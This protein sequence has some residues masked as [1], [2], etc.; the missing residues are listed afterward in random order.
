MMPDQGPVSGLMAPVGAETAPAPT[1]AAPRP[2][3]LSRAVR[4]AERVGGRIG[5]RLAAAGRTGGERLRRAGLARVRHAA[6]A[7][8]RRLLPP[9][10][11]LRRLRPGSLFLAQAEA[12]LTARAR[13]WGAAAPLFARIAEPSARL[14]GPPA[15]ALLRL[16]PPGPAL[17]LAVPMRDRPSFLPEAEAGRLVVYTAAFGRPAALPPVLGISARVRFLCFTDQ[18]LAAPGWTVLATDSG[19]DPLAATAFHKIR[20]SEALAK[21]APEARASLWLDPDRALLGNPDTLFA[22]WLLPQDFAL[23]RHPD[24]HWRAMAERHLL[25]GT[26]PAPQLLAQSE[27]FAA[28]GVPEGRGGCDTGMVW[29]R[30]DA[31]GV[32]ALCDA[33]WRSWQAAPGADDLALYRALNSPG[34]APLRP[35]I[36]PERLGPATRNL[37]VAR[38]SAAP[39]RRRSAARPARP[40]PIVFLSAARFATFASTFLRGRQL[41]AMVAAAFPDYEVRFTEDA[42]GVRDAVVVLTKGA[43]ETLPPEA[44]AALARR[45]LAAIGCWD[46]VRPEPEKVRIL[47]A[48]M[49]LSWRQTLDLNR[50]FPETPAYL[51]THH[52]NRQVPAVT[53]PQDRLRTCYFGDLGNTVR[54]ASLAGMVDL[55]GINTRDVNDNW[56][57]ALP[58]YN[59]HWIVRRTRPWDSWKPFLKGF[60][61]ARC[62][63]PVIVAADDGDAAHYLGDD[64]PFYAASLAAPDLEMA[65]ATAAAGFGGPDWTRARDIMAQVAARSSDAQVCAEFRAMVEEV[66][67]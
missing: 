64:Y 36:L 5:H 52:V 56:L 16:P 57:S 66:T 41:S 44:I 12:L 31:E 60:V 35:A 61:A 47:D 33:W 50:L 3:L 34:P 46:D 49:T 65:M 40:L 22:R 45:N 9:V 23:W 7:R 58:H 20:A 24:G 32:A 29:R 11:V 54:P 13:G 8:P 30:H 4:A 63:A 27:R 42:E 14:S 51:V 2:G 59:C 17:R 67:R 15:T 18:A 19:G 55:V 53:P 48:H 38:T 1:P 28:E 39:P 26:A 43:M 25:E 10:Q 62:G 37:F 21:A 6:L